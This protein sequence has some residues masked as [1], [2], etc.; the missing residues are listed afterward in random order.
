MSTDAN[1]SLASNVKRLII[2]YT[3]LP[4][5]PL[6]TKLRKCRISSRRAT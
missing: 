6:E 5:P 4:L 3:P 1:S 2:H